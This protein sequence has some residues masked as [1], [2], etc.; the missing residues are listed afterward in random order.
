MPQR[1]FELSSAAL[2]PMSFYHRSVWEVARDLLGKVLVTR[3]PEGSVAVRLTEVEAYGGISD[4]ACHAYGG[5]YTARTAPMYEEGGTLYIYRCYGIHAMLNLVTGPQG[6]PCAVLIRAGEPLWGIELMK[7]RRQTS[8]LFHLTVGPGRLTQALGIPL[9][10]S[11]Q[12][13]SS[14]PHIALYD[15][16][17]TVI[18][19]A[20]GPRIGVEYAGS[21]ALHP[22]RYWIEGSPFVSHLKPKNLTFA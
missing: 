21:D 14:H 19:C 1:Y 6:D 7:E 11:G 18:A 22:W 13:L 10:W 4:R 3:L 15:D 20:Q 16:G 17:Y 8:A 12:K 5:R 9:E 2:L